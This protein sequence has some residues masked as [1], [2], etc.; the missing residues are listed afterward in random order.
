MACFSSASLN[1]YPWE[2][3]I[4]LKIS[5]YGFSSATISSSFLFYLSKFHKNMHIEVATGNFW[6]LRI[7]VAVTGCELIK[8][9]LICENSRIISTYCSDFSN[10]FGKGVLKSVEIRTLSEFFHFSYSFASKMLQSRQERRKSM[11]S[12]R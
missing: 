1:R 9:S 3:F 2:N 11:R 7:L 10:S 8:S 12:V 6:N 5:R 4:A